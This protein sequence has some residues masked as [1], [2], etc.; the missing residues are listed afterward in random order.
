MSYTK[1]RKSPFSSSQKKKQKK[2]TR[3]FDFLFLSIS[4]HFF[5]TLSFVSSLSLFSFFFSFFH[6]FVFTPPP[7]PCPAPFT[8]EKKYPPIV[9][10]TFKSG[11]PLQKYT[12]TKEIKQKLTPTPKNNTPSRHKKGG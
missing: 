10:D 9:N 1:N 4:P 12:K 6:F 8:K 3:P 7:P 5:Y 11:I 2:K